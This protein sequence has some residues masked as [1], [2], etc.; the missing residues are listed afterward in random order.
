MNQRYEKAVRSI[1]LSPKSG[2]GFER[3]LAELNVSAEDFTDKKVLDL[4]AGVDLK[5]ARG[6]EQG[7]VTANTVSFSAAFGKQ[8]ERERAHGSADGEISQKIVG[9]LFSAANPRLPFADSS[10]DRVVSLHMTEHLRK[11]EIIPFIY[12]VARIIKSGGVA[13]IAPFYIFDGPSK[14][15]A[16]EKI[17]NTLLADL[18]NLQVTHEWRRPQ[19][20]YDMQMLKRGDEEGEVVPNFILTLKK[21]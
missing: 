2:R 11:G 14:Y 20:P 15:Y 9:G 10:F 3:Y 6:L 5:F 8:E 12:E 4:G 1:H 13:D 18:K 21:Q 17:D 19:K 7:G 16:N